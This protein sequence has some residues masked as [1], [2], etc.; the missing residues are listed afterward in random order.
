MTALELAF[1]PN[2]KRDQT[3]Q[4][5]REQMTAAGRSQEI[6]ITKRVMNGQPKNVRVSH[7]IP[8]PT[9]NGLRQE[10]E[11]TQRK[12]TALQYRLSKAG[13]DEEKVSG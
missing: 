1:S 13:E 7:Y 9:F 6:Q 2:F 4:T 10:F 3:A 8:T 5:S 12:S 11:T